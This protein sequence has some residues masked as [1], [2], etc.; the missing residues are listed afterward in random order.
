M[1]ISE[2]K[3]R[4]KERMRSLVLKAAMELFLGEGYESVSLRKIAD[5]IEYSP[6]TVY[7]YFKDK[8][9]ILYT[10]HN[11]AFEKFYEELSKSNR[12][13]KPLERL[14][15]LGK[16]YINFALNNP[17]HYDL[18]FIMNSP[19][20]KVFSEEDWTVGLK[21]FQL[22][23]DCVSDCIK[24]GNIKYANAN[25]AAFSVWS[26]V[27]GVVSLIIRKRCMMI[28]DKHLKHVANDALKF[29]N[30]NMLKN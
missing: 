21:S 20:R 12:I 10:L 16:L 25:T 28:P 14:K 8:D 4:E 29:L 27:H 26:F 1:S 9:E 11:I 17:Q 18:M 15:K 13:K 24:E 23:K 2:R 5:K 19:I 3:E 22:L 6:A 7:N 30:T